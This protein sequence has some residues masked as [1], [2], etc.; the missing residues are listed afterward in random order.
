MLSCR[1]AS[2]SLPV[3]AL[4]WGPSPFHGGAVHAL[5]ISGSYFT[6][7]AP[8]NDFT[9]SKVKH[10]EDFWG[11]FPDCARKPLCPFMPPSPAWRSSLLH[12]L[13]NAKSWSSLSAPV[14]WA[15]KRLVLGCFTFTFFDCICGAECFPTWDA[16]TSVNDQLW[17]FSWFVGV[18]SIFRL[19]CHIPQDKYKTVCF[20]AQSCPT[21]R[22]PMDFAHAPLS[23]GFS[24]QEYW[25]GLPFPS[26]P[27]SQFFASGGQSIGV[28]ASASVLPMNLLIY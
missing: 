26:P 9:W 13:A 14:S 17:H 5:W 24:R 4:G 12:L 3:P 18:L 7:K 20:V 22:N 2:R 16:F 21:C 27:M 15:R 28:S 23:T 1:P 11:A 8:G 6:R 25:S 19:C 10:L